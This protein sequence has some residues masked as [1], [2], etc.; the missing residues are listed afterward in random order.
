MDTGKDPPHGFARVLAATLLAP[1]APV[2]L[3]AAT[4]DMFDSPQEQGL[5]VTCPK[6]CRR[7]VLAQPPNSSGPKNKE[8]GKPADYVFR[9]ARPRPARVRVPADLPARQCP[10]VCRRR[11]CQERHPSPASPA[12]MDSSFARDEWC[13]RVAG[14]GRAES[15][16]NLGAYFVAVARFFAPSTPTFR[17]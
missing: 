5:I 3:S 7:P 8:A 10:H 17:R 11:L 1:P 14:R 9:A 6:S 12:L 15:P 16:T 4:S 2:G 13:C